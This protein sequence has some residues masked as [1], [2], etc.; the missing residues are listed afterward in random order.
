[1]PLVSSSAAD[2]LPRADSTVTAIRTADTAATARTGW[3]LLFTRPIFW[4]FLAC[5]ICRVLLY[6]NVYG[7]DPKRFI[8]EAHD[9]LHGHGFVQE[10]QVPTTEYAPG[11]PIFLCILFGVHDNPQLMGVLANFLVS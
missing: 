11:Y 7:Y 9:L 10:N 8:Q 2:C 1:M 5:V 4:A 3:R 6:Q